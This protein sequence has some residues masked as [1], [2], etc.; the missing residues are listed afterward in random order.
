MGQEDEPGWKHESYDSSETVS[1]APL[2][3]SLLCSDQLASR[4]APPPKPKVRVPAHIQVLE[5]TAEA[6]PGG[7]EGKR[8]VIDGVIFQFEQGGSKLT[9]IGGELAVTSDR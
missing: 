1:F 7:T 3:S 6:S 4:P 9:R 2:G 8:V 5:S